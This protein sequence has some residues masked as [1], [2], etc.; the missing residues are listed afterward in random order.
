MVCAS[1]LPMR[2]TDRSSLTQTRRSRVSAYAWRRASGAIE[3]TRRHTNGRMVHYVC[4]AAES[5]HSVS[6]GEA[7]AG[8]R[9]AGDSLLPRRSGQRPA[10]SAEREKRGLMEILAWRRGH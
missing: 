9:G 8:G 2:T 5:H 1:G 4:M 10:R 6:V 7:W 3:R